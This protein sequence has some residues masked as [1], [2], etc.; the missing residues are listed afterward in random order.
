MVGATGFEPVTSCSQ[1]KNE[2]FSPLIK[3]FHFS[4][5]TLD[6]TINQAYIPF[7]GIAPF[8][9][10][11]KAFLVAD[12]VADGTPKKTKGDE[13]NGTYRL[14]DSEIEKKGEEI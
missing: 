8:F 11:N 10:L 6:I 12:S 13:N 2:R 4:S 1:S 14:T 7:Q 9:T 3:T 5:K